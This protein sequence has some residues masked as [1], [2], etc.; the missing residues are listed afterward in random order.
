MKIKERVTIIINVLKGLFP[1][2]RIML[3]YSSPWELLVAVMLS[4]QCTDK[5]VHKVTEK[6]FKKY[7]CLDEY[8]SADIHEFEKDIFST[9]FYHTKAKHIL[10]S[11]RII[12]TK[13]KGEV[14]HTMRELVILPGVGRKTANVVL[15]NAYG[16][17]EGIAV[18]THV[19]RLSR[20]LGLTKNT[21]PE[22]IEKDLMKIVPRSEW[23][24]FTYLLIEY[25]R[26]YCSAKRHKHEQCPMTKIFLNSKQYDSI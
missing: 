2:A 6:L 23:V 21:N 26:K 3:N 9:G 4:A 19:I 10:E 15:G 5:Q 8:I 22:A 14:P 16:V 17:V 7:A 18:D 1:V 24:H 25:G 13:Y 11:A 20:V 12:Q